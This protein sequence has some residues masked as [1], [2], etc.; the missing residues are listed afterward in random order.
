MRITSQ[1]AS[2]KIFL[3]P[4]WLALLGLFF[5]GS[6]LTWAKD[7]APVTSVPDV[8]TTAEG[9]E[10]AWIELIVGSEK[11]LARLW[12][13]GPRGEAS[14]ECIVITHGMGGTVSGDRF[15]RLAETI[16]KRLPRAS[17]V[18]VDWSE[19]AAPKA[20][21]FPNPWKVAGSIDGV[22][23][24][25]AQ[26]LAASG[27]DPART[28]F[29]GESFG[30]W[31]NAR[32][33]FQMGG[34]QGILAL[35]PASEA[36]GYPPTDLRPLARRS[37]SLQTYSVFDSTLEIAERDFWLKTSP[38]ATQFAQHTAGIQWLRDR[39]EE[40]DL[41]WLRSE[42]PLPPR[43]PGHFRA[44]AAIDGRLLHEQV[45]RE[46]PNLPGNN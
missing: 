40:G 25:A 20:G 9:A 35:N 11:P 36:G 15:H 3:A 5:S 13:A 23:D 21:G 44:T 29:I 4:F 31:V 26:V 45:S 18:R 17:V 12:L 19:R 1:N 2:I 30:N 14:E 10:S 8:R 32:I 27:I 33:A 16:R 39:I 46:R 7:A 41:T 43:R 28:T 24:E 6:H 22:G 42:Q 38:D 34:V 37:C